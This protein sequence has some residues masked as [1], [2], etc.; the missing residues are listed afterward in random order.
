MNSII[1]RNPSMVI[2][3]LANQ[4]STPM[5][6]YDSIL[7]SKDKTMVNGMNIE[8]ADGVDRKS[9]EGCALGKQH[10]QPLPKKSERK[11]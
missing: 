11:T 10:R 3:L 7:A 1:G 9:C 2:P 5:L 4:D 6:G 8:I